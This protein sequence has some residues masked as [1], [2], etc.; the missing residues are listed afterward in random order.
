[1]ARRF[2]LLAVLALVA[3]GCGGTKTSSTAAGG[4]VP[5]GAGL[6]PASVPV[7]VTL[8]SSFGDNWK[9]L[10]AL[11]DRFPGK[12][13]LIA[14]AQQSLAKDGVDF[15]KDIKATVGPE[16]DIAFWDF[17]N[18]SPKTVGLTKPKDKG[19]FEAALKKGKSPSVYTEQ[20][21]W[22]LFS[23][24]QEALDAF[25]ALGGG[26]LD[27]DATAKAAFASV[28][29]DAAARVYANGAALKD[30]LTTALK[31][32]GSAVGSLGKGNGTLQWIAGAAEP[33]SNGLELEAVI[34]TKGGKAKNFDSKLLG[35]VPASAFA[36]F[37]FDGS[38]TA[39]ISQSLQSLQTNPATSQ[40][41][42]Q[43]QAVSGVSLDDIA[44]LFGGQGV[45]YARGGTVIPEV[46]ILEDGVDT[47]RAIRT[48]D[49]LGE[50]L[51]ALTHATP[52]S[53]TIAGVKLR[54]V[55]A[56]P[57]S[58]IYGDVDGMLVV[59]T[60]QAAIS[61]L[62]SSGSKLV[63]DKNFK[64]VEDATGISGDTEGLFYLDLGSALSA[65]TSVMQAAGSGSSS[66]PSIPA[67]VDANLQHLRS[68]FVTAHA[69][70]ADTTH[71]VVFVQTQ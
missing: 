70:D 37:S 9:A 23:D 67:N 38:G 31:S 61:D 60:S 24:K 71:A 69:D 20:G 52:Q 14:S 44:H 49:T 25:K 15:D 6:V 30:S 33:K 27:G 21:D 65:V 68:V 41:L 10:N 48:L 29:G 53:V 43:F 19:R 2:T 59:T 12:A 7:L 39:S 42:S 64:A 1:V 62:K 55:A 26:K 50:K 32:A 11:V 17:A 3:A 34:K 40:S 28:P 46:T 58:L 63:D 66:V 51:S 45:L 57:L 22:V 56:G 16:V 5:E 4:S 13:K 36:A 47:K 35:K 18:G 8:D 54:Q